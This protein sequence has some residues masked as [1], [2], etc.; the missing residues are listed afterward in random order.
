[1]KLSN[2]VLSVIGKVLLDLAV[3]NWNQ[4]HWFFFCY[5]YCCSYWMG[6]IYSTD[7]NSGTVA[8][9][10]YVKYSLMW[11]SDLIFAMH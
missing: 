3:V 11:V 9:C 10:H 2:Q 7:M 6:I 1:M 8:A 5:F 4:A